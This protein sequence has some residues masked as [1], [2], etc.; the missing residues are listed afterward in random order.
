MFVNIAVKTKTIATLLT[1]LALAA[2]GGS[3]GK[4]A[5]TFQAQRVVVFGDE[6]SLLNPDGSKYSINSVDPLSNALNCAANPLWVQL[7]AF[8]YGIVFPECNAAQLPATGRMRAAYGAKS[9]DLQTQINAHLASD[10]LGKNDLVTVLVGTHDILAQF[11]ANPRPS[12]ADMLAAVAQAGALVGDQVL[13][14][15]RTSA[16]VLIATVPDLSLTPLGR[17]A[18]GPD[19]ALLSRLSVRLN[20]QLR[21]RLDQDPNG[22]GRSGA[23]FALDETVQRYVSLVG[24]AFGYTDVVSPACTDSIANPSAIAAI[25]INSIIMPDGNLPTSCRTNTAD[26]ASG[27]WLWAGRVQFSA[28]AHGQLGA[29]AVVKLKA[30]PL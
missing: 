12:E 14:L 27:S 25:P 7:V 3:G 6:A 21:V 24:S 23:L 1:A 30:N 18:S 4:Q 9:Q 15:T 11:E 20:D 8:S 17:S 10:T 28:Y 19:Q 22:G 16:K 26:P 5:E 2:C 29:A 13:R